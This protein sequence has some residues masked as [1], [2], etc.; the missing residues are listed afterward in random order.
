ME[1]KFV[2]EDLITLPIDMFDDFSGSLGEDLGN[3]LGDVLDDVS[4][5]IFWF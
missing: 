5:F 2:F 1:N 4:N 3:D